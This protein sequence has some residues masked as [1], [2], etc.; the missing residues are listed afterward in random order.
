MAEMKIKKQ[1][2]VIIQ[3]IQVN[4]ETA[5][6]AVKVDLILPADA[7]LFV[8]VF[9]QQAAFQLPFEYANGQLSFGVDAIQA[10]LSQ[11]TENIFQVFFEFTVDAQVFEYL[12]VDQTTTEGHLS[13]TG[14]FAGLELTN[15]AGWLV[16]T[17]EQAT[18]HVLFVAEK[19]SATT[20]VTAI[21]LP[22]EQ[23]Q[24]KLAAIGEVIKQVTALGVQAGRGDAALVLP[25]ASY[26]DGQVVIN[27]ADE[28]TD[29]LDRLREQP[30][31]VQL[32]LPNG[33]FE[34][35]LRNLAGA[36]P[37]RM[38]AQ[39]KRIKFINSDNG[40][41]LLDIQ[42]D[43]YSTRFG[44][45]VRAQVYSIGATP[46]GKP[47]LTLH[48][49]AND[50]F[51]FLGARIQLR[52]NLFDHV[53]ELPVKQTTAV[54]AKFTK[55][56]VG[57]TMD[58][59][60]FYPLYWDLFA[61]VDFGNGP[62]RV[63]IEK[64][65]ARVIRRVNR[66]YLQYKVADSAQKRILV[67]YLTYNDSLAFMVREMEPVETPQATLKERLARVTFGLMKAFK[68]TK[69]NVWL[70]FEK[71]ATTAQDNGYAFFDY[72]TNNKMHDDFY[73]V[74]SADSADFAKV[75]QAH[76]DKL[77]VHGS[78]KY[79]LYLLMAKT[80]V[81]SEIRRHVYSLRVRSG[82]MYDQVANKRAVFLQ[83]GVTAFKKTTYFRN[84]ANRGSFDLV[85]TTSPAEEKIVHDYWNYPANQ[86]GLTG[87]ARWD[88]LT[89][90]SSE[91]PMKR[92]FIMPTW[93]T[94]LEDLPAED[95]VQTDYYQSFANLLANDRM[96]AVLK[97]HNLK[98]V[99][100]LHPK[101]KDYVAAFA[102]EKSE[103]VEIY[104]FGEI[105]VNE[106]IMKSSLMITDYSSVAWDTFY[107]HKPVIFYQFDLE[108]Y[109]DSWGSY[110]NMD[111]ELF[112]PR[113]HDV[114]QV[115]SAIEAS[116]TNDFQLETKYEPMYQKYFI[117]HDQQNSHRIFDAVNTM[118]ERLDH[119][120]TMD[121]GTK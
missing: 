61:L 113:V 25:V 23:L 62:E 30:L 96:M 70:G 20:T 63:R 13:L 19:I 67:P 100:F 14:S 109:L 51:K 84:A 69:P 98:L 54:S 99:F 57:L 106:E 24:F 36:Y 66:S 103:F 2:T 16:E 76:G 7:Q 22:A 81:G 37:E 101:F 115:I 112:G 111:T 73:Y 85:I 93:R 10:Y 71:F 79:Y 43:F 9:G 27:L 78:F 90:K 8:R 83:H 59:N 3:A 11:Q 114:D 32:E 45:N 48:I 33:Q 47:T 18:P 34:L 58:W 21:E 17:D 38:T 118:N 119:A 55:A 42:P 28:F 60:E 6:I 89:D 64:V 31:L 29:E 52:S 110:L 74:L 95:F 86:I 120:T 41:V 75:Q 35:Q 46:F 15:Y 56:K 68:L 92:I 108:R 65:G 50:K 116:V 87:F 105:Q 94:W 102:G 12:L 26:V 82:Y 97:R 91:Q 1:R 72:V 121:G 88:L 53:V 117:A 44:H 80:L 39:K 4:A 77:L 107:M 104:Q 40:F 5:Q 49:R